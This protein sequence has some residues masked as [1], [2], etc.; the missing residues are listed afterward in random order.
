MILCST[1]FYGDIMNLAITFIN[2]LLGGCNFHGDFSMIHPS[3]EHLYTVLLSVTNDL[4][5]YF[6]TDNIVLATT[7]LLVRHM[8]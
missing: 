2:K 8:S 6:N 3:A 7:L 1:I 4:V 5:T